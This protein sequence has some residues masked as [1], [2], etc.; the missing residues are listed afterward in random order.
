[1]RT[2]TERAVV[3]YFPDEDKGAIATK[4]ERLAEGVSPVV[5]FQFQHG[6]TTEA[7]GINGIMNEELVELLLLRLRALNDRMPCRENSLAITKFEEGLLW[8]QRRYTLRRQQGVYGTELPH[9]PS[10]EFI[11]E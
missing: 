11:Q 7:G 8:L 6:P 4:P 2:E 5:D 3:F 10:T 9:Q 1:M